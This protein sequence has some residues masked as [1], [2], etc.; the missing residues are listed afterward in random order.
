[1]AVETVFLSKIERQLNVSLEDSAQLTL[2]KAQL[3]IQI[4]EIEHKIKDKRNLMLKRLKAVN[5]LKNF[6][7]GELWLNQNFNS[8]DRNIKILKNLNLKVKR[9][10]R[11]PLSI[12]LHLKQ[13]RLQTLMT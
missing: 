5:S 2:E 6:K 12:R 3:Q 7:W 10:L 8:L 13:K 11:K 9:P 1:M 4:F